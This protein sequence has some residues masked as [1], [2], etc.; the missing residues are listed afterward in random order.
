M[1]G[2]SAGLPARAVRWRG[3]LGPISDAP[4][5]V[6]VTNLR[7]PPRFQTA[8]CPGRL[9]VGGGARWPPGRWRGLGAV[10]R[11]VVVGGGVG[12]AAS[13]VIRDYKARESK[14]MAAESSDGL[15]G[16]PGERLAEPDLR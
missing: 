15:G 1:T 11:R 12:R 9:P 2:F 7:S 13:P 5:A 8:A 3:R 14:P 16:R 4:R 10:G 6:R